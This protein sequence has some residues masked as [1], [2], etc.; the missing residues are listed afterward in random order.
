MA[1]YMKEGAH[2]GAPIGFQEGDA[3]TWYESGGMG[4]GTVREVYA[5]RHGEFGPKGYAER[6]EPRYL[7]ERP[8]GVEVTKRLAELAL[9]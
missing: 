2:L 4:G 8:D 6:P 9:A 7:V 3:V 1:R 5:A